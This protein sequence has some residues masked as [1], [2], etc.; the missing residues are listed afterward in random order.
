MLYRLKFQK[1]NKVTQDAFGKGTPIFDKYHKH[2]TGTPIGGGLLVII[3]VAVLFAI[4]MPIFT[5]LGFPLTQVF[6]WQKEVR[7]I[8]LSFFGFGL[9]GL[10]DDLKKMFGIEKTKFFGLRLK[11]KLAIQVVLGIIIASMLYFSLGIDFVNIPYFGVVNLNWLY[12][13]FAALVIVSFTNA[14]NI[15]DGLDGLAASSLVIS[16]FGLWFLSFSILDTTLAVFI[17]LW[18]GALIAFLYFN[19]FPARIIL[20]DVGSLA[21]GATL[22]VVG[23]LLGKIVALCVIGGVFIAELLSSFIQLTSK[24]LLKRKMLPVAPIHLWL[25]S[26]GWEEAKIVQRIMLVNILF[27]VF[28][29]WL[30]VL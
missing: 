16:L 14:V 9:L 5:A 10:F 18:I 3:V 7:V 25:Q 29:L 11:H 26:N 22:A 30:N 8:F 13:P 23:L 12:I 19:V 6:P 20:G 24:S 4:L 15:T 17:G 21:F 28:G 27:A 1:K 2:K